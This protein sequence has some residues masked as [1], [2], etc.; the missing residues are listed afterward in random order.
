VRTYCLNK[1]I[2]NHLLIS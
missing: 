2:F 1:M